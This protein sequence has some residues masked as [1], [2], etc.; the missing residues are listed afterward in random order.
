[1]LKIA[2][3]PISLFKNWVLIFI[4]LLICHL[5]SSGRLTGDALTVYMNIY[6]DD[7]QDALPRRYFFF[8]YIYLL[9]AI[10]GQLS[11][12]LSLP[13]ERY[14]AQV[15]ISLTAPLIWFGSVLILIKAFEKKF[16]LTRL[17]IL[18]FFFTTP[19]VFLSNELIHETFLIFFIS[20]FFYLKNSEANSKKTLMFLCLFLMIF[21][22]LYTIP[23]AIYLAVQSGIVASKKGATYFCTIVIIT[24]GIYFIP[25]VFF[26]LP[27][28][29]SDVINN[30]GHSFLNA[31]HFFFSINHGFFACFHIF[32]LTFLY[33]VIKRRGFLLTLNAIYIVFFSCL[34]H[35]HGDMVGSRYMLPIYLLNLC[36][37]I[38]QNFLT[39]TCERIKNFLI[40]FFSILWLFTIG[41]LDYDVASFN[42]YF[43]GS[44]KK[45]LV[46][47]EYMAYSSPTPYTY[48]DF[49][50]FNKEFHSVIFANRV[51]YNKVFTR[52]QGIGFVNDTVFIEL[53]N[54][55]PKMFY[56]MIKYINDNSVFIENLFGKDSIINRNVDI[57]LMLLIPFSYLFVFISPFL[58]FWYFKKRH[59]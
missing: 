34:P 18:G 17:I 49:P 37:I 57:Y 12:I 32:S 23:I 20:W 13:N 43:D 25:Q 39:K 11:D 28:S 4:T 31:F 35:W 5:V 55:Y 21:I 42:R 1:M 38:D 56:S 53:D 58:I 2:K 36:I 6:N 27:T 41:S 54:I 29:Q 51:I 30:F 22:K 24:C 45:K 15:F 9:S 14:V 50:Y 3:N 7:Y 52:N 33:F 16:D 59:T 10:V 26:N 48:W 40:G 47:L 19:L 44:A 8:L 46:D